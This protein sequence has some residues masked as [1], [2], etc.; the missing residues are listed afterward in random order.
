VLST[1]KAL[2]Q[3]RHANQLV[4]FVFRITGKF[5]TVKMWLHSAMLNAIKTA[6]KSQSDITTK[7]QL[8]CQPESSPSTV[9]RGGE[10]D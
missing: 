1:G 7:D 10:S 6:N 2:C 9:V 3:E 8:V 4:P 5:K